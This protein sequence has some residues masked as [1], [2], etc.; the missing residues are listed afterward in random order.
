MDDALARLAD[1]YGVATEYW[2]QQGNHRQVSPDTVV[3]VLAA[4]G[5]SAATPVEVDAATTEAE[6][7]SWHR[8]LPPVYVHR[9][10]RTG[11]I[12]VHVPHGTTITAHLVWEDGSGS[13][14]ATQVEHFVQPREIG[15][16]LVGEAAFEI[17]ADL[18]LGYHQFQVRTEQGI[19]YCPLIVTPD[20]LPDVE[21]GWGLMVQLYS[22]RSRRSW[23]LGDL[24]DLAE[25][26]R[27]AAEFDG[28]FVLVN[29]LYAGSPVEPIEQSPYLPVTR[30]FPDPL[31][32]DIDRIAAGLSL[33]EAE[34]QRLSDLHEQVP[35]IAADRIDRSHIW[36]VK[37]AALE[38]LW[39]AADR[40]D[41]EFLMFVSDGGVG[42]Q[43]F[44]LWCAL[45]E[46]HGPR[47]GEW[48]E[49]LRDVR[50]PAVTARFAELEER[51]QFY[52]WMQYQLDRQLAQTQSAAEAAGMGI[53]IIHDIAV[54]VHP[55]GCD[56][57]RLAG[58]VAANT[59][60]GAPP[61]MYNPMGQDWSSPPWLPEALADAA[62]VP[63]RDM[64]RTTLRHAGGIRIDHVLGLYRQWWI[65]EG[66]PPDQGTYVA[67]DHEALVGILALEADR[68][69]AVVI[70]EDLGTVAD[71]MRAD[72]ADRGILGT[73]VLWFER[74]HTITPPEHWRAQSLTSVTV[75]D[76][77]PSAGYAAGE[78]IDVRERL[79]LLHGTVEEER[80]DHATEI[81]EW[82]RL[83]H[84]RGWIAQVDAPIAE[85]V[86]GLH[87]CLAASPAVLLGVALPDLT[88]E[89]RTQNQPGTHREYP[90]WSIPLGDG[91][92]RT[93]PVEEL[94]DQELW[95]QILDVVN[96]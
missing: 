16:V 15:D 74:G 26:T 45:A 48:P 79:G 23:G 81:A 96:R 95:A 42:L 87:R 6:L 58:V 46:Q 70:G 94:A 13:R 76:L 67:M 25:L 17:P 83:L 51:V 21:P 90:N 64:I 18:P 38:E 5:V 50:A 2:D 72:M 24:G 29:P 66:F 91:C 68:V 57:W 88:G 63:Y 86:V 22:V 53:G 12:W 49:D 59:S 65:P 44:A 56:T 11:R 75:H 55:D 34:R 69:G 33:S 3:A 27:Q 10:S 7:R 52:S 37:R 43:D 30:R 47:W 62:F 89:V 35:S 82:R 40:D 93:V 80:R 31:Y 41:P 28:D 92:G 61:D 84:E 78:H 73:G 19:A 20:R 9:R 85:F 71:W 39:A 4:L 1:R 14:P 60:V 32:L 54:G 36:P 77:P 8:V